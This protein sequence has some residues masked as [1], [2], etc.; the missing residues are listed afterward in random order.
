MGYGLSVNSA[1]FGTREMKPAARVPTAE[2]IVPVENRPL[3]TSTAVRITADPTLTI[4][5]MQI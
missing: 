2:G 3:L 5:P 4:I 1:G